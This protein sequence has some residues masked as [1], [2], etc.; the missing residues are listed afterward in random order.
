MESTQPK[1]KGETMSENRTEKAS[2][3]FA[4]GE[5]RT[6]QKVKAAALT[7]PTHEIKAAIEYIG[8]GPVGEL[9]NNVKVARAGLIEAYVE[10]EG[11][12]AADA[13]RDDVEI[14]WIVR[15][16]TISLRDELNK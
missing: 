11:A 3:I 6:W 12:A 1:T 10:R 7:R 14:T 4:K 5:V 9:P 16:P 15:G 2:S 13:L 8:G